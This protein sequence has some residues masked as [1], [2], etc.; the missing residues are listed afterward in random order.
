MVTQ[1]QN[2]AK[3]PAAR[4]HAMYKLANYGVEFHHLSDD[5]KAEWRDAGG[6]QR[7]E[8]DRF[9]VDL[10]GSMD[11]FGRLEEAVMTPSQFHVHEA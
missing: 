2:L 8:W 7:S 9:K 11:A 4:A 3:V 10:A 1:A 6:Y 5:Q